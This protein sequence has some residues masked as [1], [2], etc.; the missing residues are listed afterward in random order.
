MR[1]LFDQGVPVPLK[2]AL[3]S[4]IV[5]TSWEQGWSRLNNGAL[6][7][8]AEKEFDLL[9]TTDQSLR[10]QQNVSGLNLAILILPY[11]S[12]P[13]LKQHLARIASAVNALK[14]GDVI[15]LKLP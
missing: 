15:E 11:A 10:H 8:A 7:S 3:E 12:W 9:V 13:K 1:I 5:R 2:N 6:L 4:H 14:P